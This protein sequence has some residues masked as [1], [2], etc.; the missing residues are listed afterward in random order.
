M[1]ATRVDL[2]TGN[3]PYSV[4]IGDLNSDGV[5][6]LSVANGLSH[7]ISTLL[8]NGD[9]SFAIRSDWGTGYTPHAITLSDLDGDG[10]TDLI[11]AN[12][13][14]N[15]VSVL[16]GKGDGTFASKVDYGAGQIPY[17][18][19]IADMDRDGRPDVAVTNSYGNTITLLLNKTHD[20]ST[21]TLLSF[22]NGSW[23]H[24]GV[25]VRWQFAAEHPV[26]AVALERSDAASGPWKPLNGAYRESGM[27]EML[28]DRSAEPGRSYWYR[29]LLKLPPNPDQMFGPLAVAAA[30]LAGNR[31]MV[32]PSPSRGRVRIDFEVTGESRVRLDVIDVQGRVVALLID[33][34]R[35]PGRERIVWDGGAGSNRVPAGLYFLRYRTG[36]VQEV[37]MIALSP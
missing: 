32:T 33:G 19:T 18:V 20:V 9:G 8:G 13:G 2:T 37:R 28:L 27:A 25:E 21:A 5:Q 11:A 34:A 23:G 31:L 22:F 12:A 24:D 15:S 3:Y 14:S 17:A 1:F 35:S 26:D 4:A 7:T 16:L 30:S 36:T 10:H 29:L 6:D